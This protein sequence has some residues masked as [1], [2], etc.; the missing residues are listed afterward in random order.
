MSAFMP[1]R[2]LAVVLTDDEPFEG[3]CGG[4]YPRFDK[5]EC[6]LCIVSMTDASVPME[7][8]HW[9]CPSMAFG[10]TCSVLSMLPKRHSHLLVLPVVAWPVCEL[11]V[12][13]LALN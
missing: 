13:G 6:M 7:C 4:C 11:W 8:K 9:D 10:I 1:C 5:I 12:S 2:Q 3:G